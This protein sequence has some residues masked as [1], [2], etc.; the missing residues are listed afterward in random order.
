MQ[1]AAIGSRR[2]VV[3]SADATP[4][5]WPADVEKGPFLDTIVELA[6]CLL[7]GDVARFGRRAERRRC[8]NQEPPAL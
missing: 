7:G 4:K 2:H 5:L 6:G 3:E 1:I 8:R